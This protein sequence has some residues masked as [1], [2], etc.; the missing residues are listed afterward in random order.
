MQGDVHVLCLNGRLASEEERTNPGVG[1]LRIQKNISSYSEHLH[2][3]REIDLRR[4]SISVLPSILSRDDLKSS[5]LSLSLSHNRLSNVAAL[6]RFVNL[7]CLDVS[8]NEIDTIPQSFSYLKQ[9]IKLDLSDNKLRHLAFQVDVDNDVGEEI[10]KIIDNSDGI[11][12]RSERPASNEC[13]NIRDATEKRVVKGFVAENDTKGFRERRKYLMLDGIH[14]W[15]VVMNIDDDDADVAYMYCNNVS[16]EKTFVLPSTLDPFTKLIHLVSLKL[17][18]NCLKILPESIG[19]LTQLQVFEARKNKLLFVPDSFCRLKLLKVLKLDQ[20]RLS[21]LPENLYQCESLKSVGLESNEFEYFPSCL[22]QCPSLENIGLKSNA[23]RSL[24]YFVGF[25]PRLVDINMFDNPLED[26]EYEF[27]LDGVAALLWECR[28]RHLELQNG[29]PPKIIDHPSGICGELHDIDPKFDLRMN[30]TI[31]IALV[32]KQQALRLQKQNLTELPHQLYTKNDLRHLDLRGNNFQQTIQWTEAMSSLETLNISD[33]RVTNVS[34]TI[35]RLNDLLE[36]NLERNE[37]MEVPNEL[38]ELIN[39]EKL[40]LSLNRIRSYAIKGVMPALRELYLDV[41]Q[42]SDLPLGL[43]NLSNLKKLS[44]RQ[45]KL[46]EIDRSVVALTSLVE[47]NACRNEIQSVCASIGHMKLASLLLH[48]NQISVLDDECL[49]PN[50]FKTLKFFRIDSN[51]LLQLPLCIDK[52]IF[53]DGLKVDQNPFVSPPQQLVQRGMNEVLNYCRIRR[54]RAA[55][56]KSSLQK[57]KFKTDQ[58]NYY[59]VARGVLVGYTGFLAEEDLLEFDQIVDEYLNGEYYLHEHS[60]SEIVSKIKERR[61]E[62][63]SAAYQMILRALL[64]VLSDENVADFLIENALLRKDLERP[65]GKDAEMVSCY[66]FHSALLEESDC[67]VTLNLNDGVES[68][69][70]SLVKE[71]LELNEEFILGKFVVT[72]E[73]IFKALQYHSPYGTRVAHVEKV[74]YGNGKEA[75]F[76]SDIMGSGVSSVVIVKVLHTFSEARRRLNEE[77]LIKTNFSRV[78]RTIDTWLESR[79]GTMKLNNETKK[80]TKSISIELRK[81][82]RALKDEQR[83]EPKAQ[84]NIVRATRKAT[85]LGKS[86]ETDANVKEAE[87]KL[88]DIHKEVSKLQQ[89]ISLLKAQKEGLDECETRSGAVDDLKKKYCLA[90]FSV[91]YNSNRLLAI[92]KGYRRPW[93]GPDGKDFEQMLQN[94]SQVASAGEMDAILRGK[95][96]E[97]CM[98]KLEDIISVNDFSWDGAEQGSCR[99]CKLYSKY[100]EFNDVGEFSILSTNHRKFGSRRGRGST[101][102]QSIDRLFSTARKLSKR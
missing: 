22:V 61:K 41:N 32:S 10:G 21:E 42:I 13:H 38:T 70:C 50:L 43:E 20:N 66:S 49:M 88:Q 35:R 67:P 87:I 16:G 102:R 62:R 60:T 36:L 28:Q 98:N 91:V 64:Q 45:N 24:P 68:S 79:E 75:S 76:F 82:G 81:S 86:D 65:W 96:E 95:G 74:V 26:P 101:I 57:N 77:N 55:E 46:R 9:L 72:N 40:N 78:E 3:A 59:P 44:L 29:G 12:R 4:N 97:H 90:I 92:H 53:F 93:D 37:I 47:L 48:C 89:D 6:G 11:P 14:E 69:L 100:K 83:K 8:A 85:I 23:I 58:S 94:E 7:Q 31:Q 2:D 30:R 52:L 80:R 84:E 73:V 19:F 18:G 34:P 51:R 17:S 25:M 63:E 33:S 1:R 56:L 27:V 71:E 99:E 15:D 54:K 5:L 39:L